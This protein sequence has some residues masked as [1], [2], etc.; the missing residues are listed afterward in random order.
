MAVSSFD[1]YVPGAIDLGG[2]FLRAGDNHNEDPGIELIRFRSSGRMA[3]AYT[4]TN[5]VT[6]TFTFQTPEIRQALDTVGMGLLGVAL[7]ATPG[8]I[9]WVKKDPVDVDPTA[10][11]ITTITKGVAVPTAIAFGGMN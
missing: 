2:T 8:L 10:C 3:F 4:A 1:T 7:D 11:L 9:Y 6:P 5:R